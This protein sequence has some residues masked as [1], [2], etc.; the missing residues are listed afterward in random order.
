MNA[1]K[2]I[3][4]TEFWKEINKLRKDGK[5][6]VNK[7]DGVSGKKEVCHNWKEKFLAMGGKDERN[8]MK[9]NDLGNTFVE[10]VGSGGC[11]ENVKVELAEVKDFLKGLKVGKARGPDG[12]S[13]E[14]IKWGGLVLWNWVSRLVKGCFSHGV[15][16]EETLESWILPIVK[17]KKG[18]TEDSNNYRGISISSVWSKIFDG[19]ILKK[20]QEK[21]E[22]NNCQFGFKKG[23]STSMAVQTV[24]ELGK[25]YCEKGGSMFGAFVDVT[26]AFDKLE[27][28]NIWNRL[29]KINVGKNICKM[30]RETYLRQ[31]KRVCWEGELSDGF[32]VGK[33]VRQGSPL[34]PFLFAIVLDEIA[35]AVQ[36]LNEGCEVKGQKINIIIY[37]DD[38]VVLGPTR[39]AIKKILKVLVGQLKV[40]G[41]DLNK[42][43]T[44]VM[45]FRN[46]RGY[47]EEEPLR[48]EGNEFKWVSE[49]KYLG[50]CLQCNL[51]WDKHVKMVGNKMNKLGNMILQQVGK[52]VGQKERIYLLNVCAFDLYGI[53]FCREVEKKVSG[54]V[55]KSYHWLIK[56]CLGYSKYY[57]N[58][59]A[60]AESGLLTWE[61]QRIWKEYILWEKISNS[62]NEIMKVLFDKNKWETDL[63]ISV[64]KNSMMYGRE[65]RS[66]KELKENMLL[67]IEAM[68]VLKEMEREAEK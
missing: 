54:D 52:V 32:T 68:A 28:S 13:G 66:A 16:L 62:S 10:T 31:V 36:G 24:V 46:G 8:K 6:V 25:I 30:V 51:R 58:H 39:H 20:L 47:A 23:V 29:Q 11:E 53:E 35:E 26:K 9:E 44:V 45:H 5:P 7:I 57:G 40:K 18:N 48:V 41:L 63:G 1:K 15:V 50:V 12:I 33:G 42:D 65:V 27:Y 3:D 21:H 2:N 38:I 37:A 19:L 60:C 14:Q 34:S 67:F 49:V 64:L 61:L 4:A 55:G 17:D 43:K 22:T 56:R 59:C